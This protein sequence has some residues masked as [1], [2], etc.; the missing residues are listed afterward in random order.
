MQVSYQEKVIALWAAFLFGTLFHI[1]M[2]LMPLFYGFQSAHPAA[3]GSASIA[4]ILWM[5]LGFF[6]IPIFAII[7]TAFHDSKRYCA[8][9]FGLTILYSLMNL[10]HVVLDLQIQPIVWSQMTLMMILFAIGLLLNVV[11]YQ[12]M[13]SHSWQVKSLDLVRRSIPY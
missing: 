6:V 10:L 3:Q 11:A 8:V 2:E 12:W 13:R 7:V 9:H 4:P 5:M 1:Q